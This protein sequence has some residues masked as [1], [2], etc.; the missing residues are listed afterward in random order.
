MQ[1]TESATSHFTLKRAQALIL[2][3]PEYEV[4][5]VLPSLSNPGVICGFHRCCVW[6]NEEIPRLNYY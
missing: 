2:K 6:N 3:D 5:G 1:F 4:L